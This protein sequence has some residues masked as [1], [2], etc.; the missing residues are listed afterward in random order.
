MKTPKIGDWKWGARMTR[1]ERNREIYL[2]R[3]KGGSIR[4]LAEQYHLS[5][6]W[7]RKICLAERKKE[8]VPNWVKKDQPQRME[9]TELYKA[10]VVNHGL[11]TAEKIGKNIPLQAY[12]CLLR[13]WMKEKKEPENYP[14]VE[15]ICSLSDE[16]IW[17]MTRVGRVKYEFLRTVRDHLLLQITTGRE[18]IHDE[19]HRRA[20]GECDCTCSGNRNNE[21]E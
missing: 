9:E 14:T 8:H 20:K 12:N 17:N 13:Q 5:V 15:Y 21:S 3:K 19:I 7:I 11:E 16:D 1:D 2:Q 6:E 4:L 10:I 18:T